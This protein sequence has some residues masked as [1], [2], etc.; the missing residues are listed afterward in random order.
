MGTDQSPLAQSSFWLD[1]LKILGHGHVQKLVDSWE[2]ATQIPEDLE[3]LELKKENSGSR[4]PIVQP[5]IEYWEAKEKEMVLASCSGA[6]GHAQCAGSSLDTETRIH[7]G[8]CTTFPHLEKKIIPL[9]ENSNLFDLEFSLESSHQLHQHQHQ[10][11]S[12]VLLPESLSY[13][14][15][16]SEDSFEREPRFVNPK[17]Y[18]RILKRR[19]QRAKYF[20]NHVVVK[21]DKPYKHQSRHE[22]AQRRQRGQ[23]GRFMKRQPQTTTTPAKKKEPEFPDFLNEPFMSGDGFSF[24]ALAA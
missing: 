7:C 1:D 15:M 20:Q 14:P 21:Q 13:S 16:L 11:P 10:Q 8:D 18:H 22:H 5:L 9:E 2:A 23:G 24:E 17:Q 6:P 19:Q 12:Q 4:R 3:P